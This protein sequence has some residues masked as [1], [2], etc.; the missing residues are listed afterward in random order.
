MKTSVRYALISL[1]KSFFV[2]EKLLATELRIFL[3]VILGKENG[4]NPYLFNQMRK[5][6]LTCP[7][8]SNLH[9]NLLLEFFS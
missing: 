1:K 8:T 2:F 3:N 7:L 4:G 9:K 5:T 6:I